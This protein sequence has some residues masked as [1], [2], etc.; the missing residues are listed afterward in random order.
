[1]VDVPG[2]NATMG[3]N[4]GK[5]QLTLKSASIPVL[6][7]VLFIYMYY[8]VNVILHFSHEDFALLKEIMMID[9]EDEKIEFFLESEHGFQLCLH[10]RNFP[11]GRSILKNVTNAILGSRRVILLLSRLYF[12][13]FVGHKPNESKFHTHGCDWILLQYIIISLN[14]HI[15]S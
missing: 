3:R 2:H 4:Y 10:Q 13:V 8:F 6:C 9:R 14:Q 7:I 11:G 12:H 5:L 15:S 1:M